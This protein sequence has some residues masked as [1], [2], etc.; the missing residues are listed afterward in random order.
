ML[1]DLLYRLRAIFRRNAVESELNEELRFHFNHE[2]EK[3]IGGGAT[4]EEA[5]RR[6]RLAFGG[7]EQVKEDC[8]DAR[9]TGFVETSLQDLRYAL[10]QLAGSP[11]FA[12]VIILT[13]ALSIG[14]NSAIFSVISSVLIKSLPYPHPEK[15]VRLF[16]TNSVY[17]R[18][19]LNHFD[20]RD[21]RARSKSFDSMAIF[22]RGDMQLSGGSAEPVR[23]YGF[24]I[25]SG[26]FRVLGQHPQLGREFDRNAEL[27]GNGQPVLLSDRLWR[28]RFAA[29]P[30][31][32][33]KKI[34]LN[35]QP[36]TVIGVMPRGTEHPG[37]EYHSLAYGD[38]VDLW[39]PFTFDGDP[40][41]RGSHYTE[42]IARLKDGVTPEQARSELN[43]IMAELGHEYANDARWHVLVVPLYREV[44]GSSQRMLL[45]LLGASGWCSSSRVPMPP[46]CCS[47]ELLLGSARSL[48]GWPSAHLARALFASC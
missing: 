24:H 5:L 8:R 31:I 27:P 12:V 44:V 33:G 32:V 29:D 37:N 28:A 30:A 48:C 41:R 7:H 34:T 39:S 9:G 15:I 23:L 1:T 25:T 14:A 26:Y 40:T 6:A 20:F 43:A 11:G 36:F 35:A 47:P 46:I 38:D 21:Y 22:T 18:F 2:V 10:R 4:R 17:P 3:Y 19:P 16:L 42:G 13:L 45:V